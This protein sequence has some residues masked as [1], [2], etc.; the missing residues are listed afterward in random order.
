M[1]RII[2]VLVVSF[3]MYILVCVDLI[4][5]IDALY[6]QGGLSFLKTNVVLLVIVGN[7]LKSTLPLE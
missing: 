7:S 3:N 4:D 2:F 5:Y 6:I 1:D